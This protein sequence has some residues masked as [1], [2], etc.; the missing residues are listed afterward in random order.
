[1]KYKKYLM[2]FVILL[3][4]CFEEK[5][6]QTKTNV[7]DVVVPLEHDYSEV[8]DYELTWDSMFDV[9]SNR[10]YIYF[11]SVSCNH[12][13]EIKNFIIERALERGDVYFVKGT[14]KD[15][16]TTDSKKLINA[17]KPGDFYIL[18]YPSLALISTK[19]CIKNLAGTAQIKTELK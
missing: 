14:S 15:Q 9:D 12:C 8:S 6:T 18:G 4:G 7:E 5:T 17:E 10:Y 3:S 11:Y 2:L 19:K 13:A 1:M 16:L